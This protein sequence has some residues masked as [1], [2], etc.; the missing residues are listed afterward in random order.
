MDRFKRQLGQR[1]LAE[2]GAAGGELG[3]LLRCPPHLVGEEEA[4]KTQ[5]TGC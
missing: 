5:H 2:I 4:W 1:Q 3:K